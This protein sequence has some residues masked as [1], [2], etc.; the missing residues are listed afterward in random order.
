MEGLFFNANDGYVEG[1]VRGYKNNLLTSSNYSTLTQCE[2]LEGK[3]SAEGAVTPKTD[4]LH[5]PETPALT[6]L[7][8]LSR[9]CSVTSIYFDYSI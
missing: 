5:R 9:K 3:H 1:I 2:T 4:V 7:W 8:R 6:F